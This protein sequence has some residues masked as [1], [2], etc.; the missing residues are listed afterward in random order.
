[1]PGVADPETES[2]VNE[3]VDAFWKAI[4]GGADKRGQ[5][6]RSMR[7]F[8]IPLKMEIASK[9][10]VTF[11][12]KRPKKSWFQV[13][14]GEEEVPWEQW[15]DGLLFSTRTLHYRTLQGDQCGSSST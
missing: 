13:Y 8:N 3:K 6:S 15:F 7:V 12:E 4:E 11:S 14:V 10:L 5:V 9:I 1:M 2:L